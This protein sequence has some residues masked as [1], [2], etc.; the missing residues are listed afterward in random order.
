[1]DKNKGGG[2]W[3]GISA[4]LSQ[5][6][7]RKILWGA[8]GWRASRLLGKEPSRQRRQCKVPEVDCA[9]RSSS[10]EDQGARVGQ[11]RE[12]GR[13]GYSDSPCRVLWTHMWTVAFTLSA[14]KAV[15][16]FGTVKG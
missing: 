1:M 3:A 6:A 8:E 11:V 2:C 4:I 12:E 10:K 16:G 5:T 14:L 13:K 7:H 15:G 9:Y